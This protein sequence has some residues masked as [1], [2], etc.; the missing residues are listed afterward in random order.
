MKIKRIFHPIGQGAFYS[1]RHENFTIVYDCGSK[2]DKTISDK[3]VASAFKKDEIIDILFISHF[4]SD[5]VNKILVLLQHVKIKKVILPLL[6]DEQKNFLINFYRMLNF[7][8]LTL[9]KNPK[10]FF[11]ENTD[12]IF[13]KESKDN[14]PTTE[15]SVIR[16]N[17]LE[18]GKEIES[19]TILTINPSVSSK[20]N[21]IFVPYNYKYVDRN[22]DLECKLKSHGFDVDKLKTDSNY[23][24]QEIQ[25]DIGKG[26]KQQFKKIYNS[27]KKDGK[28]TC[29]NENSMIVYSGIDKKCQAQISYQYGSLMFKKISNS[30][31]SNRVS[32]VYTGDTDL[33]VAKIK[34]IYSQHWQ[35]V[36]TIQI[37]HH[38]ATQNFEKSVLDDKYY[39]CPISARSNSKHHPSSQ[40][41]AKIISQHSYPILISEN[42]N[43]E[44]VEEITVK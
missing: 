42:S 16:I 21:W 18:D 10:K 34:S 2:T 23:T 32:C 39:I 20:P 33:N 31:I 17:E 35:F 11:G 28:D 43:T 26:L 44:F 38:G 25:N 13:V 36:S 12:I 4:D 22:K 6:H 29:I 15:E 5:H 8:L 14:L 41:V 30:T 19:G 7:H 37:P 24:L 27:L 9:I 1:E 40:V 3:V